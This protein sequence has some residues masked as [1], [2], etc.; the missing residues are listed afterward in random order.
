MTQNSLNQFK[1]LIKFLPQLR[2]L[3]VGHYDESMVKFISKQLESVNGHLDATIYENESK[4][5]EADN[6]KYRV[7]DTLKKPFRSA[8]REYEQLVVFDIFH[9]IE[10]K[11]RFLQSIFRAL[12]NSGEVALISPKE[13]DIHVIKEMMQDNGFV[14]INDID[15]FEDYY[16]ISAK[17]MHGWSH[18]L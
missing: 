4:L 16:L 3:Y 7:L 9:L 1:E 10:N 15:I 5:Y 18:G 13:S 6:I 2:M 8:S 11:D 12:E 17:K 14:A